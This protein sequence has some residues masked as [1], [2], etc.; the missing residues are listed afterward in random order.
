MR[1]KLVEVTNGERNWGKMLLGKFDTEWEYRS[2]IDGRGLIA[3]RGWGPNTLL[4]LD[5]QTGEGSLFSPG[6][7]AKADLAKHQVWVCPMFE[8][9]LEW[10]WKQPDPMAIPA[11][12]DLPDAPFDFRGYR[13]EGPDE[14][15]R[16]AVRNERRD[17][18]V[19]DALRVGVP[20]DAPAVSKPAS[21]RA[22]GRARAGR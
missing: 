11:H 2:V 15:T 19:P 12:V 20:R 17:V 18:P 16:E 14:A 21:R 4:V 22:R 1:I 9:F 6:G 10:L 5:L 7:Y 8:P 3:G 13:R